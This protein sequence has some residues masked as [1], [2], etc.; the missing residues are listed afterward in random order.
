MQ[1][2]LATVLSCDREGCV[3]LPVGQTPLRVSYGVAVKDRIRIRR[4]DVVV[5]DLVAAGV[6]LVWRWR[7]GEVLR[8]LEQA[9]APGHVLVGATGHIV[10]ARV[11]QDGL[12]VAPGDHVCVEH[13]ENGFDILDR[14]NEGVPEHPAWIRRARFPAIEAAYAAMTGS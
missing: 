2:E 8:S 1:L 7:V 14:V 9:P 6:D 12:K 4:G 11:V 13:T 10:E 3:V 5:V